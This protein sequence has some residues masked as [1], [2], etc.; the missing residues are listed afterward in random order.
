M[1]SNAV[2]IGLFY[3]AKDFAAKKWEWFLFYRSEL[4][5]ANLLQIFLSLLLRMFFADLLPKIRFAPKNLSR[6]NQAL[7]ALVIQFVICFHVVISLHVF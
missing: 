7:E 3:K 4:F 5:A 6:G 2:L 1:S